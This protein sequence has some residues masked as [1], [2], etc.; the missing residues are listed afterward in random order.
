MREMF[1][2]IINM[3]CL[4]MT[5]V[6]RFQNVNPM[7]NKRQESIFTILGY[8]I[9]CVGMQQQLKNAELVSTFEIYKK[10]LEKIISLKQEQ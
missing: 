4:A 9:I 1:F 10:T 3:E 5:L 8:I 7:K 2:V 6:T